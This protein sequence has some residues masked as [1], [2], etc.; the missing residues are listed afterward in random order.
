[1]KKIGLF[2]L[3]CSPFLSCQN[4]GKLEFVHDLPSQMR[5]VS[6]IAWDEGQQLLWMVNDSGNKAEI[7]GFNIEQGLIER[8]V[9]LEGIQNK[10]WEDLAMNPNGTLYVGDFGNN[11]NKRKD[12]VIY[13][14]PKPGSNNPN[15][16]VL[17]TRY[18][19]ADQKKFP[20]KRK[21]RNFDVESFVFLDGHFYLFTRNRSSQFDG[22]TKVYKLPARAG[23]QV[24]VPVGS[25][26][27]CE[28]RK[29]CE[30]TAAAIDQATGN[31]AVLSYNKVWIFSDF[32][33]D[34]ITEGSI[35]KIKLGHSSQKESL[36]YKSSNELLIADERS[37][38][39]G[40]NLYLLK[41]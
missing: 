18:T 16:E 9:T 11:S 30:I 36:S 3:L 25:F 17:M 28:D 20:P 39:S 40:R 31:I 33:E 29:D 24:A 37:G 14:V 5:E 4:L 10:D 8:T 22:T 6:G 35:E 7:Y 1:M 13:H 34:R 21:Y 27:S 23:E 26:V 32:P 2:L 12:L 38:T 19:Y 41:L 15:E